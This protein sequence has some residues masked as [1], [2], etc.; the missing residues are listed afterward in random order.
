MVD[1]HGSCAATAYFERCSRGRRGLKF[2]GLRLWLWGP[3]RLRVLVVEL[4][5]PWQGDGEMR[6]LGVHLD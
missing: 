6:A 1:G 5:V 3:G 2:F 4:E